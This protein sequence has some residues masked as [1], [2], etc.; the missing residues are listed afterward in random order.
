MREEDCLVSG[1]HKDGRSLHRAHIPKI[2]TPRRKTVSP[3]IS[4]MPVK[5]ISMIDLRKMSEEG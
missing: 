4:R 3:N 5:E 1:G 2:G